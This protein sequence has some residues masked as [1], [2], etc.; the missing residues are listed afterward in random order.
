MVL[1]RSDSPSPTAEAAVKGGGGGGVSTPAA[2]SASSTGVLPAGESGAV[3]AVGCVI[4]APGAPAQH[5]HAD[6]RARGIVN[7]FIPLVTV[8]TSLGPTHFKRGSHTWDHD[9][10]YLSGRVSQ[11]PSHWQAAR[12]D[13]N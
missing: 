7:V 10:P 3:T 12:R 9:S 5:F 13:P 4:S 8:P 11:G 6:G 2:A 1:E